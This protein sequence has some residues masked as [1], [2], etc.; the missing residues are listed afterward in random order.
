MAKR[1]I[2]QMA[3]THCQASNQSVID[4]GRKCLMICSSCG[5]Q[6]TWQRKGARDA[7][8]ARFLSVEPVKGSSVQPSTTDNTTTGEWHP[9][10][11]DSPVNRQEQAKK[12]FFFDL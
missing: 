7:I 4:D 11:D 9:A 12:K 2:G 6:T 8:R 1:E 10:T 3:C 5:V